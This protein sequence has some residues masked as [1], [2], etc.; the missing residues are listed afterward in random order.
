[1]QTG[2]LDQKSQFEAKDNDV[3]DFS[4]KYIISLVLAVR[5]G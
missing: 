3:T 4:N 2:D 1:M 5:R